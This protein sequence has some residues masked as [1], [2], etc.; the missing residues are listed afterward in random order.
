MEQISALKVGKLIKEYRNLAGL[1]QFELAE[2]I[3][4]DERQMS[5][6]ERGVHYPSVPTFLKLIKVL[7]IDIEKLYSDITDI[8]IGEISSSQNKLMRFARTAKE[9]EIK[10][11]CKILDVVNFASKN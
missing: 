1:T 7:T 9:D 4:I 11:A 8:K 5:K 10:L 6:I 3:N 2:I